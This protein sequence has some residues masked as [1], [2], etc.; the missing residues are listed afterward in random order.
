MQ[1]RTPSTKPA[2]KIT[3]QSIVAFDAHLGELLGPPPLL[4]GEDRDSY[5]RLYERVWGA[6]APADVVEE[7]W[8]RDVVDLVW[9]TL[10]LRR[11]RAKLMVS[12]RADGLTQ[13][14]KGF[15]LDIRERIRLV[16]GWSSGDATSRKRV[17]EMLKNA[18]FDE[19]H[20]EAETFSARLQDFERIDRMIFQSEARRN[21]ALHEID[22]HRDVLARRLRAAASDIVDADFEETV[23]PAARA[24]A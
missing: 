24:S 3:H 11:L 13:I 7:L 5:A 22:R 12:A 18:G 16:A 21:S 8:V 2:D 20:L 14:L 1:S 6:V 23:E 17:A 4:E 9:E 19:S 15:C 10:R